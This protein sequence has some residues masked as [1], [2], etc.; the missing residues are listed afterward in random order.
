VLE[1][2]AHRVMVL[3]VVVNF[4]VI[5]S[6]FAKLAVHCVVMK[7]LISIAWYIPK[8]IYLL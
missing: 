3:I 4:H 1:F 7:E 8:A 2:K 6:D 5:S